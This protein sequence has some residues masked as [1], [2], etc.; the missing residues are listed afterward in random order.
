MLSSPSINLLKLFIKMKK[1][2]YCVYMTNEVEC[3]LVAKFENDV[4]AVQ[5]ALAIHQSSNVPHSVTVYEGE[6]D[7]PIKIC[8]LYVNKENE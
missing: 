5:L 8:D 7:S 2:V 6:K 3:V 4:Q 1:K